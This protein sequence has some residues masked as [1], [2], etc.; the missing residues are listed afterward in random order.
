ML[1]PEVDFA[2]LAAS[3]GAT[4]VRVSSLDDLDAL[5]EWRDAGATGTILLDCG[6]SRSVVA[7][8]QR[9]I[10]RVNGVYASE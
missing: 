2:S 4:S 7:D 10:Q 1:I 3:L 6:I 8:Y 5:A 9:E